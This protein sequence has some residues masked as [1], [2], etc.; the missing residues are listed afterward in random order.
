MSKV[1]KSRFNRKNNNKPTAFE[2]QNN[3]LLY[4]RFKAQ[5]GKKSNTWKDFTKKNATKIK[6]KQRKK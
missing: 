4:E 6:K 1:L 2:P 3:L 5:C